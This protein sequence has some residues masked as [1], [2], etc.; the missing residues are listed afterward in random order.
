MATVALRD[1]PRQAFMDHPGPENQQGVAR[2]QSVRDVS[3][4]QA[5]VLCAV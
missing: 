5:Q 1:L 4:K 3:E 2:A